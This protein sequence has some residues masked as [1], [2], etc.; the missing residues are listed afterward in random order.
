MGMIILET[1]I[2]DLRNKLTPENRASGW[3]SLLL[4]RIGSQAK[5]ICYLRNPL[6]GHI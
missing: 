3:W 6:K 4:G 1:K 5:N 2:V